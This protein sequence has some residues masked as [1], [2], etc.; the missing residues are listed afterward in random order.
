MFDS[1]D[2]ARCPAR[3][4]RA[5]VGVNVVDLENVSHRRERFP[6]HGQARHRGRQPDNG[7]QNIMLL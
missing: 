6:H 5:G 4:L 3:R 1:A 2:S 7:A